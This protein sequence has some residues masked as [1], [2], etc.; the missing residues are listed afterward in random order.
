MRSFIRRN[1]AVIVTDSQ[2]TDRREYETWIS[3]VKCRRMDALGAIYSEQ[4]SHVSCKHVHLAAVFCPLSSWPTSLSILQLGDWRFIW[5]G[6]DVL[7]PYSSE[8]TGRNYYV[9][10]A[11]YR[12]SKTKQANDWNCAWNSLP[13]FVKSAS[14]LSTFKRYLK[15]YLFA[16]SY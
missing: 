6:F 2:W 1:H 9:A 11:Q 10:G 8:L 12:P 16:M 7:M 4:P 5:L 15:T 14:S 13:S 3:Q